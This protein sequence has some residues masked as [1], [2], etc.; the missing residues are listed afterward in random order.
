MTAEKHA[1]LIYDVGLHKGE[2]TEFYLKKG[3]RV[4]AFEANPDLIRHCAKKFAQE[5]LTERLVIIKGAIVDP[6]DIDAE[7]YTSFYVNAQQSIWGTAKGNWVA[8][9]EKAATEHTQI[10]VPAV[11]FAAMLE[12]F[13]I[14]Y[15]MKIDIEGCDRICLQALLH[16]EQR[17]DYLSIESEKA[18][19][20]ELREEFRLLRKLGYDRFK[21]VQQANVYRSSPPVPAR[22]GKDIAHRFAEG[23]SGVF[24][25]ETSGEWRDEARA[26]DDY[27]RIFKR[28]RRFGDDSVM[29]RFRLGRKVLKRVQR[30]TGWSLPGWYDTHAKHSSVGAPSHRLDGRRP[31]LATVEV[32]PAKA[33]RAK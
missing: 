6:G 20:S 17:P 33:S 15:Y 11:D 9:N 23:A 1:D 14:P 27:A 16:F 21:A 2:D 10:R 19:F 12:R 32:V 5:L 13:G 30:I 25:E 26:L 24:G 4:I 3:F 28:Y 7:G 31:K 29:R 18:D 22:E 8:R